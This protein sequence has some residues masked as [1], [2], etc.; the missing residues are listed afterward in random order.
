MRSVSFLVTGA[1]GFIGRSLIKRLVACHYDVSILDTEIQTETL[2]KGINKSYQQDITKKISINRYFDFVFHLA[3]LNITHVGKA[4]WE[5]YYKVNVLGT[6]NLIESVKTKNFTIMSTTKVYKQEGKVIDETS[7]VEPRG[8][9]EKTKLAAEDI[10]QQ[11]F[12]GE[13]LTILRAVNIV[14]PSQSNKALLPVLFRNAFNDRPIDIFIPQ[15]TTL[16]LLYIDDVVRAFELLIQHGGVAG[17]FN[18]ATPYK[19]QIDSLASKIIEITNSSS[20]I[21]YSNTDKAVF[22]EIVSNR[23]EKTF[24]WHPVMTI[25]DILDRCCRA[26]TVEFKKLREP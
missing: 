14:G 26:Y 23:A 7:P 1:N 4:D 10:C 24:G 15:N 5:A 9:Y 19:I 8:D 18:L 2:K 16:Q 3:A 22:S 25:P 21:N 13:Y 20:Q 6:L 17:I 11:Y 12:Q